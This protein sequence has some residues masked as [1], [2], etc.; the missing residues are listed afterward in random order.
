M[1]KFFKIL[2]Y[3]LGIFILIVAG[4]LTYVKTALPNVG[5]APSIT[6]DMS[7]DKIA[8]GKYLAHNVM[9]CMDC[10][11]TRDW[12]KFAGPP[13]DGTWGKG[14]ETFDQKISFPGSFIAPNITPFGI[15]DWTD[16]EVFRAVTSGVSKD[17]RALFP[18]MPHISY[19]KLDEEDIKS[20]IAYIRTLA[21]IENTPQASVA[22]FP[23]NFI[24]NTIP[25]KPQFSK[26]PDTT[27]MVNYGKYVVTAASC[28]DC[29]TKQDKGKFVG[30]PFAGGF[31]FPMPDGSKVISANITPHTSGIG[32][33]TEEQFVKRFKMYVDSAYV[34][35][36]VAPGEFQ[37]MMPWTMYAGMTEKDLA[38]VYQYLRTVAPVDLT[39][40]RFVPAQ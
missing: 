20:V 24:I 26:M 12:S 5:E 17:G 7:A 19:G 33:W 2:A 30:E 36:S 27:D 6:V 14:G 11:S 15:G 34:I 16:G 35:P 10:H 28:F 21:P 32:H 9:V 23:M 22:D 40:P 1:K 39:N 4:L 8:R 18:I 3:V 38:A 25:Q 31:E 13:M 37:T 29:H